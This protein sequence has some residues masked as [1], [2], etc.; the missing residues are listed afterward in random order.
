MLSKSTLRQFYQVSR[1]NKKEEAKQKQSAEIQSILTDWIRAYYALS[2]VNKVRIAL[3]YPMSSEVQIDFSTLPIGSHIEY[4]LPVVQKKS[5]VLKFY[6]WDLQENS[7][8]KGAYGIPVPKIP[9]GIRSRTPDIVVV[10]MLAYTHYLHRLG[11]GGGY[12][13]ATFADFKEKFKHKKS[14]ARFLKIGLCF[15]MNRLPPEY[16]HDLH[17]QAVDLMITD[18]GVLNPKAIFESEK[19]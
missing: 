6:P 11:Y 19:P 18:E 1:L 17:D 3:Y 7:L 4:L 14:R 10:P 5:R 8:E 16:I 12:Y 2:K 15:S 9:K 13:D